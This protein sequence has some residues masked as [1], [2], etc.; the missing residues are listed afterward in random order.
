VGEDLV[1]RRQAIERARSETATA[2]DPDLIPPAVQASWRRSAPVVDT[3]RDAAPVGADDDARERWEESPLH[4]AVPQLVPQLEA[5]ARE[6]DI[7][8]TINDT[9][10]RILWETTPRWLRA[11]AERIGLLRGG[12]WNEGTCG[13]NGVGLAL[14][15]DQPA[16]VFAS[17][18]WL[19]L[20]RDWVCYAA[21]VHD[22]RGLQVGA[23]NLSTTW[24]NHNPLALTTVA[25]VARL[26]EHEL[27]TQDRRA[28]G[29]PPLLDLRVLGEAAVSIDG[30]PVHLT[31]RQ[32]EILTILAL[33][34][35]STLDELHAQLYGDRPVS[36]ATLRSEMSQLR[37]AVGGQL[38]AR[39]YRLTMPCR[40]DA[41]E[42]LDR[43]DA[44]DV[45]RA[46]QLY[47]GQLL[48]ASE[49]PLLSQH[50]QLV[51]VALRAALV[52]R[53]TPAGALRYTAVH[54]YDVEVLEQ[55]RLRAVPGD[56]LLPAVT[57][58]MAIALSG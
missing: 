9:Q 40:V 20:G 45:E 50:R 42:L 27:R 2:P 46:A 41:I 17:E 48:P 30:V 18:H 12:I 7:I 21:P 58:R 49:S 28:A 33:R 43:L 19:T 54:P 13:T 34:G 23:I 29:L 10:G 3:E 56:P 52:G 39:P 32:Y 47:A 53:G 1:V 44:G 26:V 8:A 15:A 6:G 31:H 57:A 36:M 37:R 4:R 35:G 25:S 38:A 16:A 11:G 51:D 14:A 55:A 24:T 5:I 22:A